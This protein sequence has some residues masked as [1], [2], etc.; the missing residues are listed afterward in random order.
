MHADWPGGDVRT[1]RLRRSSRPTP[2]GRSGVLIAQPCLVAHPPS[3]S[4]LQACSTTHRNRTILKQFI[5]M[6][7]DHRYLLPDRHPATSTAAASQTAP[8]RTDVVASTSLEAPAAASNTAASN[9]RT[10]LSHDLLSRLRS[11]NNSST[12]SLELESDSGR[13]PTPTASTPRARPRH[14]ATKPPPSSATSISSKP[15]LVRTYSGPRTNGSIGGAAIHVRANV[16]IDGNGTVEPIMTSPK[17]PP[18]EAFS[19]DGILRAVEPEIRDALDAIAEICARSRYSLADEY[20]AH[21]PPQG[22]IMANPSTIQGRTALWRRFAENGRALTAVP[23]A[24][25]SSERLAAESRAASSVASAKSKPTAYASLMSI[26][27]R[28]G[29]AR[30]RAGNDSDGTLAGGEHHEIIDANPSMALMASPTTSKHLVLESP[31]HVETMLP[32]DELFPPPK[33]TTISWFSWAWRS[34]PSE[35]RNGPSAETTLKGLLDSSA[36]QPK[37]ANG[38]G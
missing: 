15:V 13:P 30:S 4:L 37:P 6:A 35:P 17:L 38:F 24:S 33:K 18:V 28:K 26:M 8:G 19:F 32:R 10:S 14:R 20:S 5:Q 29:T 1:A 7:S 16:S 34:K 12:T 11:S 22:E 23:E 31:I 9:H 21:L 2:G 27:I 25:S 36:G 3:A